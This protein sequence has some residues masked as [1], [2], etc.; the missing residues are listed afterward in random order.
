MKNET[1]KNQQNELKPVSVFVDENGKKWVRVRTL[2]LDF[3]IDLHDYKE[4]DKARF[5]WHELMER[6]KEGKIRMIDMKKAKAIYLYI[7][8]VN[9]TLKEAG[10]EELKGWYWTE[11]E[12]QYHSNNAWVFNGTYGCLYHTGKLYTYG[13]RSLACE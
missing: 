13:C 5:T 9:A 2:D 11:I 1:E 7:D 6:A 10:G 8:E 12:S 3:K 4:G